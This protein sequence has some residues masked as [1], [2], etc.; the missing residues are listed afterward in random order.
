M[1][2][3][4]LPHPISANRYWRHFRGRTVVSK[5]AKD[6][7]AAV[8][9]TAI[10]QGIRQAHQGAITLW[11]SYHPRKPKKWRGGPCRSLDLSN[12]LKVAEDALNGIAWEDDSQAVSIHLAKGVPVEGGQLVV[13][14]ESAHFTNPQQ[15]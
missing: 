15:D 4:T 12:V 11:V 1:P 9:Q 6:Y 3:L 8:R 7:Q 2:T 10:E 14:W 13:S 5:E